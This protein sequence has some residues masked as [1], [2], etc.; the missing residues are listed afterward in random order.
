MGWLANLTGESWSYASQVW[1]VFSGLIA[2]YLA[3][4]TSSADQI[5]TVF[6]D[7][8]LQGFEKKYSDEYL[9]MLIKGVFFH[10]QLFNSA[11]IRF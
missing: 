1:A 2:D 10:G 9:E 5:P 3:T 6:V 4:D 11:E 8:A 7:D